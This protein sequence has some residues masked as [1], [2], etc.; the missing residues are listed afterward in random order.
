MADKIIH[1]SVILNCSIESAFNYFADND[2]LTKWLTNNADVE[3]KEGGKYEL[4]WTPKDPDPT[5]NSTYGCKVL[6][7]ERPYYLNIEWRGNAE[8]KEFMNNVRP[9]TNVTVLFLPLER[10]KTKVT[11]IHTGWRQDDNWEAARQYFINAWII[12]FKQLE[13]LVNI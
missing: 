6:A 11:L 10:K 2:L 5:N 13:E 4:F 9:L 8:Q 12:A 7:V 1:T 3:M